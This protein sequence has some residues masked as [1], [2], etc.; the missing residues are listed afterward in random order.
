MDTLIK[1]HS[2]NVYVKAE[3]AKVKSTLARSISEFW[4][5]AESNRFG[6]IPVLLVIIAGLGGVAVSFGAH[7]NTL[8]LTIVV[9]PSIISLAFILAVAPMRL[10]IWVSVFSILLDLL[11]FVF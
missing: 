6:I 7:D 5:D 2:I 4:E 11:V 8:K 1:T 9:F 3:T 10:I